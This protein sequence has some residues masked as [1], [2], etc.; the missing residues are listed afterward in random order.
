[1]TE[2]R[3]LFAYNAWANARVFAAAAGVPPDARTEGITRDLRQLLAHITGVEEAYFRAITEGEAA[4]RSDAHKLPDLAALGARSAEV[5]ARYRDF[6][7]TADA[8]G[9]ARTLRLP[10]LGID[11]SVREALLQVIVHSVEHRADVATVLTREGA[12]APAL[13]LVFWIADGRP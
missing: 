12:E 5:A 3:E 10:W 13:D 2:L 6:L 4:A 1:M 9:L 8:D 7:A 11:F